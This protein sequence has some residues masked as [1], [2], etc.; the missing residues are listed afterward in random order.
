MKVKLYNLLGKSTKSI[1]LSESVFRVK[2]N[3][4]LLSQAV[5]TIRANTRKSIANTK[6]RGQVRG[7]GKKPF[8]QKGTGNARAGSSRSPLWTGGGITFGPT[9]KRN[10]TKKMPGKMAKS[11]LKMVLSSKARNNQLIILEKIELKSHK[12]KQ[13][14]EILEKLPIQE[15][16]I[17]VVIGKTNVNLELATANLSYLK[18]I[19][20]SG[21]NIY[22]IINNDY[23]LTDQEG[24]KIIQQNLEK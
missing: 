5:L 21:I 20:A 2:E 6:D 13:M 9:N 3:P 12:T 7:G 14:Q 8:K 18:T 4:S 15:G 1:D 24:I 11:A 23:L 16:K 22:D 17:L 19:Q 10:F